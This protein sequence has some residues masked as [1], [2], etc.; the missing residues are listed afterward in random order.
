MTYTHEE[1][2]ALIDEVEKYKAALEEINKTLEKFD[3]KASDFK[4]GKP[5]LLVAKAH[6]IAKQ[7]LKGTG[8]E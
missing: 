8:H 7:A 1:I 6:E 4:I 5:C 2:R 3:I